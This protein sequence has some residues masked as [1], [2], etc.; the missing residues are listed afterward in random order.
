MARAGAGRRPEGRHGPSFTHCLSRQQHNR[1][2]FA[3]QPEQKAEYQ[4]HDY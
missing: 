4:A 3:E 2:S 1:R